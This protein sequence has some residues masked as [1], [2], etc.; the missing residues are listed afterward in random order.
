MCLELY[1]GNPLQL[2]ED[3]QL[4]KAEAEM[5]EEE[6]YSHVWRKRNSIGTMESIRSELLCQEEAF[7]TAF[8]LCFLRFQARISTGNIL[9]PRDQIRFSSPNGNLKLQTDFKKRQDPAQFLIRGFWSSSL[10]LQEGE[11]LWAR[12]PLLSLIPHFRCHSW[13][14]WLASSALHLPQHPALNLSWSAFVPR[15]TAPNLTEPGRFTWQS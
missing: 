7:G 6:D 11:A 14:T 9:R 4:W 8:H 13:R 5:E 1:W 15:N 10:S 12:Q 3:S 2:D